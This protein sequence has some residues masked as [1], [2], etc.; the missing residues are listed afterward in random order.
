MNRNNKELPHILIIGGKDH[1]YER[2]IEL[3]CRYS[4]IQIT[5][6]VTEYQIQNACHLVVADYTNVEFC[7][8]IA[9]T[10]HKQDS[11]DAIF[12]FSEYSQA[13]AAHIAEALS[14][15]SNCNV[16][17]ISVTRDKAAMRELLRNC[18]VPVVESKLVSNSQCILTFAELVGYP[19]ILKPRSG[20][21]SEGIYFLSGNQHVESALSHCQL[22]SEQVL[23]EKFINGKEYSVETLSYNGEHRVVVI[24]EKYT[25]EA[26]HFVEKAHFQPAILYHADR[27]KIQ[28]TVRK[29]LDACTHKWG[30]AHTEIKLFDG[31]V[32]I[33]ET[34]LRFGGDQ[35]W[36]MAW[37]VSGFDLVKETLAALV[38]TAAPLRQPRYASMSISFLFKTLE[39]A[40]L[41]QLIEKHGLSAYLLRSHLS[42]D[43]KVNTI[44]HSGQ[45]AGYVLFG[46]QSEN[47]PSGWEAFNKEIG[48]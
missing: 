19:I 23:A 29:L 45:R 28:S 21:G 40:Q 27:D 12:S 11:F 36:E 8:E 9:K 39:Q 24:T 26:P 31:E 6:L 46:F 34:Q 14:L 25:S 47:A 37:G 2:A 17:A 13:A 43:R 5:P 42:R 38:K 41:S 4:A 7:V 3:Q 10:L 35:I 33:I 16:E 20:A 15:P 32:Y 22:V 30:P 1:T 18:D 44:T 48:H